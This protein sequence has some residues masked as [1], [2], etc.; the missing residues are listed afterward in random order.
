MLLKALM[1]GVV[2]AGWLLSGVAAR[3]LSN[4]SA[5]DWIYG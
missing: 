4:W 5:L 3:I 2:A 1:V